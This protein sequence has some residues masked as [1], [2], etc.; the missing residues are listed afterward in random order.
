M[1]GIFQSKKV[2][3]KELKTSMGDK[4]NTFSKMFQQDT[5]YVRTNC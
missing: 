5:A 2:Y 1:W 3:L 4:R